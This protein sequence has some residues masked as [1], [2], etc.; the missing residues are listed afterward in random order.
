MPIH[1]DKT[2]TSILKTA[3]TIAVIGASP[4]PWRDSGSIAQY[5]I[6]QGYAVYPVNPNY[7][8]VLGRK[9][10]P[11]L[12]SIPAKIDIVDIFRNP[13]EVESVIDE[14]IAIHAKTIW[15]QLGVVNIKAAEKAERAGVRVIMDQCIAVEHTRLLK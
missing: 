8:E 9:C 6:H 13:D 12:T 15:M 2:I 11:D 1:D 10:Y 3:K 4:K 5:L 14:A 7:P